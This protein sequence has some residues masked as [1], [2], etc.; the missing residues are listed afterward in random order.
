MVRTDK[1]VASVDRGSF[2]DRKNISLHTFPADVRT[3]A[4][5][6]SGDFV[7][8]I[9]EDNAVSFH[10]LECNPRDLIHVDQLLLFFLNQ[11]L[12]RLGHAH[13]SLLSARAEQSGDD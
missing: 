4:T 5:F 2:D 3:M 10:P 11:I 6:A 9:Q 1:A 8:L 13:V 12:K 7:Y